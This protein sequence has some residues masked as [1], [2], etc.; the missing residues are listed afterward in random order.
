MVLLE[1][2]LLGGSYS[3]TGRAIS[4]GAVWMIRRE[5]LLAELASSPAARDAAAVHLARCARERNVYLGCVMG[6]S[7][8][9]KIRRLL[10]YLRRQHGDAHVR[11]TH[12]DIAALLGASRQQ[13]TQILH[14]L[15]DAGEVG[16][17][18]GVLLIG[19]SD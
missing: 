7:I 14:R 18:Y 9:S 15:A 3:A 13:V 19:T 6:K 10:A 5:D 11:M 4:A 2:V 8:N 12:A 17:G 16:L 1:D